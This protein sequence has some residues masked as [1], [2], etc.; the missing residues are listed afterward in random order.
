MPTKQKNISVSDNEENSFNIENLIE[1]KEKFMFMICKNMATI[2]IDEETKLYR[3]VHDK[4]GEEVHKLKG[5]QNDKIKQVMIKTL[6]ELF[7]KT[8]KHMITNK[9]F[10]IEDFNSIVDL[11][12]HSK[13]GF[14]HL[15]SSE[16]VQLYVD[17]RRDELIVDSET[18]YVNSI[19]ELV[20]D[21]LNCKYG[22]LTNKFI[23]ELENQMYDDKMLDD[24]DIQ[25]NVRPFNFKIEL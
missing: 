17:I 19:S 16:C 13:L 11:F 3:K 12:G 7:N 22:E 21:D 4:V 23:S 8:Y 2:I 9:K 5:L 25:K 20:N 15:F 6:E 14:I 10:H 18:E 24:V 1:K